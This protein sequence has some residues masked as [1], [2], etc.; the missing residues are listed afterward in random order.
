MPEAEWYTL[1]SCPFVGVLQ[2]SKYGLQKHVSL[3]PSSLDRV[4]HAGSGNVIFIA[5]RVC[6]IGR[7]K[8]RPLTRHRLGYFRTHDRLGEGG[9]DPLL[10]REPMVVSSPTFESSLRD[11]PKA[12]R[13][14]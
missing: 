1:T 9:F 11:L 6:R 14:F 3:K 8:A 13:R 7:G 5:V 4:A 10:F 2:G 12:Y